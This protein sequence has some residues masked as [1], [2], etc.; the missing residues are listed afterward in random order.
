EGPLSP[1]R[2]I[3]ISIQIARAL[4][5]AHQEGVVHRDL[6]PANIMVHFDDE[7]LD[8]VKVLDF[9]LVKV[10]APEESDISSPNAQDALTRAGC[11]VGTPEY[12]APEQA[13]GDAV[14]GRADIYSLGILMFQMITGKLPYSGASV[15]ETVNQ[16]FTAAIPNIHESNPEIRCPVDLQT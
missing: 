9:G 7:G 5:K 2:A 4:R 6:K 15:V 16:H 3:S 1:E 10:F 11:M 13:L 14:D 12:V 8:R